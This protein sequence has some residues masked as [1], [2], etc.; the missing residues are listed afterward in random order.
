MNQAP[1]KQIVPDDQY[2]LT[3]E[4][5]RKYLDALADVTAK[6][7]AGEISLEA[8]MEAFNAVYITVS[9]LVNWDDL[10]EIMQEFNQYTRQGAKAA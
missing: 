10:N 8:M 7:D 1:S 2:E 9:G 5:E 4:L 3:A 6:Y